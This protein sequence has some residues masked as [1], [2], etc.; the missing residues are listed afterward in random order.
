MTPPSILRYNASSVPILQ[1][2][3]SS[4]TMSESSLY[5]Y[6]YYFI[7]SQTRWLPCK[8]QP[9]PCP[10]ADAPARSWSIST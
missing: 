5:D 7:R 3:I 4:D 1:M 10:T 9:S 8:A 6:G 2:S